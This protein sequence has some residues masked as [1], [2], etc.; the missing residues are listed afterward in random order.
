MA[1][2]KSDVRHT[3]TKESEWVKWDQNKRKFRGGTPYSALWQQGEQFPWNKGECF[4]DMIHSNT[5]ECIVRWALK[6]WTKSAQ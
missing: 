4:A 1:L 6:I 2:L 5:T 3:Q